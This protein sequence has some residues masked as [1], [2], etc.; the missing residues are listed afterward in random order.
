MQDSVDKQMADIGERQ[1]MDIAILATSKQRSAV[2]NQTLYRSPKHT[3]PDRAVL[4][5]L[6]SP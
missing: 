3:G 6:A 2:T 4:S 1:A 5:H